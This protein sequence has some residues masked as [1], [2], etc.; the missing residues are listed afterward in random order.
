[1]KR[2]VDR[3]IREVLRNAAAAVDAAAVTSAATE[4]SSTPSGD[5]AVDIAAIRA[6]LARR[7]DAPG[8]AGPVISGA[9]GNSYRRR[10]WSFAMAAAMAVL[11]LVP[12]AREGLGSPSSQLSRVVQPAV[13]SF[14]SGT[15]F[16]EEIVFVLEAT[17][18]Y[19]RD[20]RRE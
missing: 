3:H 1:M 7:A 9:G 17:A 13:Q 19:Y 5:A 2:N 20:D 6:E 12:V 4:R 10:G 11:A 16:K 15:K 14:L 18:T 8:G